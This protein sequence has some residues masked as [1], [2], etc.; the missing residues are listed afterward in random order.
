MVRPCKVHALDPEK[1]LAVED[2]ILAGKSLRQIATYIKT[3]FKEEVSFH[4]IHRHVQHHMKD[5]RFLSRE[6]RLR[7]FQEQHSI[8]WSEI[9]Q[10]LYDETLLLI[11]RL[12][13][14]IADR[15]ATATEKKDIRE[16]QE[17]FKHSL[18]ELNG[19]INDLTKFCYE[20]RSI[21]HEGLPVTNYIPDWFSIEAEKLEAAW[22]KKYAPDWSKPYARWLPSFILVP[23]LLLKEKNTAKKEIEHILEQLRIRH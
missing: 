2:M 20:N 13:E 14:S 16:A 9:E 17:Y 21:Q 19:F 1:R 4:S 3:E 6:E 10:K 5:S 11:L 22:F 12:A 23:L 18:T 8:I 15:L 7:R